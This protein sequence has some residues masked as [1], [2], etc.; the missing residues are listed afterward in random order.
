MKQRLSSSG[1]ASWRCVLVGVLSE[2]WPR[3][4]PNWSC[5]TTCITHAHNKSRPLVSSLLPAASSPG[6]AAPQPAPRWHTGHTS[7]PATSTDTGSCHFSAEAAAAVKFAAEICCRN[8]TGGTGRQDTSV[9]EGERESRVGGHA[10][11]TIGSCRLRRRAASSCRLQT[12]TTPRVLTEFQPRPDRAFRE[13]VG[14]H[15]W[16]GCHRNIGR[17]KR[18][19]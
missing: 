16:R 2:P 17:V 19:M 5:T 14:D 11:R 8:K 13:R 18:R 4:S 15:G 6:R 7:A 3:N 9:R 10:Q 12:T 1:G